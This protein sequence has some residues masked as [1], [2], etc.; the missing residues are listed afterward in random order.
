MT[1]ADP[2]V[3]VI[4][5]A[6][7]AAAT[8]REAIGSVRDQTFDNWEVVIYDDGS[9]D[10]TRTVAEG[11]AAE[12]P[13]RVRVFAAPDGN[14]G[15]AE[16]TNA[17]VA[18]ARADL[19]LLVNADDIIRPTLLEERL[20]LLQ[21]FPDAVMAWGPAEYFGEGIQSYKQPIQLG[22]GDVYHPP[23]SLVELLIRDQRGTPCTTG[24]VL[25]KA[26]YE[27]VGG[28][29]EGLRRGEDIALSLK[30]ASR[31]PIVYDDRPLFLYRRHPGSSTSRANRS[32]DRAGW[33]LDF[34]RWV[35]HF[36]RREG[37]GGRAELAAEVQFI[38]ALHRFLD[39]QGRLSS[40]RSL[41]RGLREEGLLRRHLIWFALDLVLPDRPARRVAARVRSFGDRRT[42]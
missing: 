27:E 13:G 42:R 5:P 7:Q 23:G 36:V 4:V 3:S 32:G 29:E 31:Y 12:S 15:P 39:G 18:H 17:A 20:A 24:T 41:A 22:P 30:I 19:L 6:F 16:A 40:R 14:R 2:H 33:D 9:T 38:N 1:Q 28:L 35:L 10:A 34:G 11:L 37:I 8:L 25:N 26:A 21:R